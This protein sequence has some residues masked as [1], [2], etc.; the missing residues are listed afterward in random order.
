[1]ILVTLR[2]TDHI[3]FFSGH[4]GTYGKAVLKNE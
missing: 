4:K 2:N 1:M 3:L